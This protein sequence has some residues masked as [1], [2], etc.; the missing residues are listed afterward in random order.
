MLDVVG[1]KSQATGFDL[2][3]TGGPFCGACLS[4]D[5]AIRK[6]MNPVGAN[7][8]KR[9]HRRRWKTALAEQGEGSEGSGEH[10]A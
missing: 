9:T 2:R 1:V 4:I 8:P 7:E 3:M 10:R 6:E 5:R